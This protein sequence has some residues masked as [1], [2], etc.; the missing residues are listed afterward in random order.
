MYILKDFEVMNDLQLWFARMEERLGVQLPQ[1]LKDHIQL[2]DE[3]E[4]G[5]LD[6]DR[7]ECDPLL[8]PV[9]MEAGLDAIDRLR[10][11]KMEMEEWPALIP[12]LPGEGRNVYVLVLGGDWVHE[13]GMVVSLWTDTLEN[14]PLVSLE[15]L[16]ESV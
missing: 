1:A 14:E 4:E 11:E 5:P 8:S 3:E 6:G 15:E 12:I 2:V 10:V 13:E 16:L 9:D 7:V